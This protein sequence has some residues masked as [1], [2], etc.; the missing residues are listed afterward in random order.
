V[1]ATELAQVATVAVG[2][3]T[4]L[5]TGLFGV[6]YRRLEAKL[7]LGVDAAIQRVR[8][9]VERDLKNHEVRLRVAGEFRLKL[10]D[11]Q[12]GDVAD[13]RSKLGGAIGAIG[14]LAHEVVPHGGMTERARALMHDAQKAFA[15]LAGAGPFMPPQLH[16]DAAAVADHFHDALRDVV[17]WSALPQERDRHERCVKTNATMTALSQQS[18]ALFG[19]WQTEQFAAF[20]SELRELSL[21]LSA[22]VELERAQVKRRPELVETTAN[23]A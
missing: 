7:R 5:A 10:L 1:T 3:V 4:V 16:A 2:V 17:D 21:G 12:M 20:A 11:R 8:G 18:R 19:E 22:P 6:A 15:A 9:E 14:L 23:R 13:F